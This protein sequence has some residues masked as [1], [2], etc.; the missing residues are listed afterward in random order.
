[1]LTITIP[2]S[3]GWDPVNEVFISTKAKKIVLEHSLVSVSKWE[4][5][6][7]KSYFTNDKTLDEFIE[8]VRCMTITQNVPDEVYQFLT[9]ENLKSI[10]DYIEDPMTATKI[11]DSVKAYGV[12]PVL[13]S[14]LIYYM[15]IA[16]NIP[17]ECHKWHLNRLLMLIRVCNE[18]N[19][20]PKKV[21]MQE[22]A[23]RNR[24][25]KEARRRA[26]KAKA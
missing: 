3:E 12:R 20:P 24:E 8:Y 25:I 19:Q 22:A 14:E 18:K 26:M 13:T 6:H 2:E 7:K 21:S 5:R 10:T 15:M 17:F 4:S 11:D 23:Q 16:N 9:N 1:M